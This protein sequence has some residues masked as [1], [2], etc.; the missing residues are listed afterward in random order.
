MEIDLRSEDAA[1]LTTIAEYVRKK[2]DLVK[3]EG[4]RI[5][6][7]ENRQPT[8]RN[9]SAGGSISEIR[10]GCLESPGGSSP[11]DHF[12]HGCK[13]THP[14]RMAGAFHWLD[15]W[16]ACAHTQRDDRIASPENWHGIPVSIGGRSLEGSQ[17]ID[18]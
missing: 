12:I 4:V 15:H 13:P 3:Q 2:V 14:Q 17:G 10:I 5:V 6:V 11:H 18:H 8:L 9:H 1:T 16:R 7:E